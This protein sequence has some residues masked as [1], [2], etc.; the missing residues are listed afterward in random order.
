MGM[1][2]HSCYIAFPDQ[3]SIVKIKEYAITSNATKLE[4]Y[5]KPVSGFGGDKVLSGLKNF[6]PF[7]KKKNTVIIPLTGKEDLKRLADNRVYSMFGR[8]LQGT[9]NGNIVVVELPTFN[10]YIRDLKIAHMRISEMETII[11]SM[12]K[13]IQFLTAPAKEQFTSI[14]GMVKE[15]K[16]VTEPANLEYFNYDY[17]SGIKGGVED[18]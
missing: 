2:L 16:R 12:Q 11:L 13:S 10:P 8:G 3:G 15:A 9:G 4:I 6:S 5:M 18:R 14:M 1:K 7:N 17:A